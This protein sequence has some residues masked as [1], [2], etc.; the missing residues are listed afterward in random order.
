MTTPSAPCRTPV[1][2]GHNDLAWTARTNRDYSVEGL[3]SSAMTV[4]TDIPALREGNVVGQFWSAWVDAAISGADAVQATLEQIDFVHRMAARYPDTFALAR[5]AAEARRGIEQGRIASLIGVEGGGQIN[6]SLA[7]LREYAR[8]GVRYM[9]LTWIKSSDWAD[10]ATDMATNNGLSDFGRSVIAEMNRI[11]MLVDLAHVSV[12]TM[13]D[14]LDVSTKPLLISHSGA[15]ALNDHPRN[16][17][18]EI[19]R[20]VADAGG[21]HMVTFVPSFMSPERHAWVRAGEE[22]PKP[23]VD[24]AAVADHVEHVRNVGGI[25]AVGLGGD[26]DGTDDMPQGLDTVAAYPNLFAELSRRG[27]TETELQQLGA[28][29]I[30]RVL[31]KSDADYMAFVRAGTGE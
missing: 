1:F 2:D 16:V 26:F 12:K 31:E 23:V 6:N 27:W 15:A 10:S 21:V 11:G 20:R 3:E 8:L 24:V 29:N 30:M 19:I 28:G 13:H 7:V 25:D 5:T 18:D 17:P 14:A 4:H 9:T 22:G